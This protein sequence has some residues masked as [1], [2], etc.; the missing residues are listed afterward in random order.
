M[1]DA[2]LSGLE[3]RFADVKGVQMR[4]FVGGEGPPL[5]LVHGLGGA[6]SNWTELAPLLAGRHTTLVHTRGPGYARAAGIAAGIPLEAPLD[7]H[8]GETRESGRAARDAGVAGHAR[9]LADAGHAGEAGPAPRPARRPGR[10]G[11]R[12]DVHAAEHLDADVRLRADVLL[13]VR[14]HAPGAFRRKRIAHEVVAAETFAAPLEG[15]A[16]LADKLLAPQRREN[17]LH[18]EA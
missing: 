5:V 13:G 16:R 7:A 15:G 1:T 17:G 9:R 18:G 8:V 10:A 4:Y 2:K 6:A 11:R 14:H 12:A 3:E